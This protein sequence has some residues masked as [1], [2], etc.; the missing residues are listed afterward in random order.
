M[1]AAEQLIQATIETL[2]PHVPFDG[3]EAKALRLLASRVKLAYFPKGTETVG[4]ASG[5]VSRLFI[6]K[7]GVV[8]GR[9]SAELP[10]EELIDLVHGPG[11]CFPIGALLGRRPTAYHYVAESDVFVYELEED[12]FRKLFE[13]SPRFQRFCTDYLSSLLEQS[14]RALRAHAADVVADESRML[15]PLRQL[16]RHEPVS[17]GPDVPI[18]IV[19]Q[20]MQTHG[21]GSM[22]V[23]DAERVPIGIFTQPDLLQ[24]VALGGKD[25]SEPISSVMTTH[26]VVLDGEA[27]IYA[28][29]VTMA[30]HGIRHII[31][32]SDGKLAGVLSERDLFAMQRVSLRRAAEAIRGARDAAAL[33]DAAQDVR[34]LA[35]NLLAQGMSSEHLTQVISALNDS[36]TQRAIAIVAARHGFEQRYCWIALGSEGRME[37]T[38]AT[39]QDNALIL[40]EGADASVFI[41]FADEV[42]R[43]LDACGFPLCRG[44]IMARNPKWC[45]TLAQ[46]RET[47]TRWVQ[48]PVPEALLNA[49]IFFDFRSL[50]GEP[51]FAGELREWLLGQTAGNPAFLRAMTSNALQARPPLGLLRDFVTDG[52]EQFPGTIDLK[53]LGVR[54]L[55]DVARV[56]ALAHRLAETGTAERLRA[57]GAIGVLPEDEVAAAIESFHFIQTLRL[58][59]QHFDRPAPGAEN[60]IRPD[61]LNSLDRR[62]LKEAFRHASKLQER[63]RLDY[64]L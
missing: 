35:G 25:L 5:A 23:V 27:P 15:A 18:R 47:F 2:R 43:L 6:V 58:R 41:A 33:V 61:T 39:D 60:R 48:S 22:I 56:W 32:V 26:P 21:I 12:D 44:D 30:R 1:A 8:A 31:L 46:W 9:A 16:A 62:I 34:Q 42:N 57:A 17:C 29:A 10:A 63:L 3:M 14:R 50:A 4:P 7:Q 37:Q 11:E 38:L 49:A 20:M 40:D 52:S 28:A 51:Q 53:Q 36:L 54:P 64:Q 24:R 19:L 13:L 59:H 55:V 45:L